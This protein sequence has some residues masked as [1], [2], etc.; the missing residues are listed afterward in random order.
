MLGTCEQMQVFNAEST[1]VGNCTQFPAVPA[2]GIHAH[3][4][5]HHS[6]FT[7]ISFPHNIGLMS[8]CLAA[9]ECSTKAK[10]KTGNIL[11]LKKVAIPIIQAAPYS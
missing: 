11:P 8:L 10:V 5:I 1:I 4:T 9:S 3:V 6:V 7:V 2:S